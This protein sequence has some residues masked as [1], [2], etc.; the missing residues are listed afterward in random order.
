MISA[1]NISDDKHPVMSSIMKSRTSLLLL[2]P[3][4]ASTPAAAPETFRGVGFKTPCLLPAP[5]TARERRQDYVTFGG[6]R[7]F[8]DAFRPAANGEMVY[9]Y[10]RVLNNS[11]FVVGA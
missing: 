8:R 3:N 10:T 6:T 7:Y 1:P 11:W 2:C 5:S 4:G 9:R